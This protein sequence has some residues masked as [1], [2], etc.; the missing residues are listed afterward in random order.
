MSK[1]LIG[2]IVAMSL[3]GYIYYNF[4]VVPM[5]NKLE[6]QS[7]VI[8]AQDLRDQEQKAAITAITENFEKTSKA[9]QGQQVQNEIYQGQMTEYLDVFRRHNL[10]KLA[11]AKPGLVEKRINNGTKEVFNAIQNDSVRISTLND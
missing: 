6:E 7:K 11:S 3:G 1:I 2:I 5:I 9:L 10:G 8:L 4:T